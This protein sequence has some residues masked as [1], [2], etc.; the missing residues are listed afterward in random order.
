MFAR[1]NRLWRLLATAL[2]FLLF[3][4]GALLLALCW[5]PLLSLVCR[6]SAQRQRWAQRSIC[7]SFRLFLGLLCALGVMSYRVEG[8]ALL[9]DDAGCL[10]V[11]NHPSLLDYVLLASLL[12]RC[13]C[14]VK[15]A[16][17]HNPFV[18]GVMRAA[19]YLPNVE[20][21]QLLPLCQQKLAAGGVLLIFPEGT[22]STPGQPLQL[23]RGAANIAVRCR[24]DLRLVHILCRPG[25]LT[26]QA[27]WYRI[28]PS[29]PHFQVSIR[30]KIAI[31]PFVQDVA[32]PAVA[33]RQL[34]Q[35]LTKALL[36]RE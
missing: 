6:E 9:V 33:A 32:S 21:E 8:E 31:T 29:R 12:P 7:L 17:W 10:L 23:Q 34:T 27:P 16:L 25:T 1:I 13:D 18:R 20:A 24:A 26:K 15:Q 3:G 11:A 14:I 28:P 22:R 2:S 30:E 35:F 4:G 5:F 36:P 19:G